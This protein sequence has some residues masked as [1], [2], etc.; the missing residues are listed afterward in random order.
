MND[1]AKV[2][3]KAAYDLLTKQEESPFVLNLLAETVE[4]DGCE[5]DGSCLREDI[6]EWFWKTTGKGLEDE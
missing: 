6:N 1:R 4:Y 2:L 5:C 3:L